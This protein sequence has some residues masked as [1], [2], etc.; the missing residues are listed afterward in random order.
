MTAEELFKK[1]ERIVGWCFKKYINDYKSIY[2]E[3][4]IQEGMLALWKCAKNF[5]ESRGNAFS[6]YAVPFVSGAMR[7]YYK[8]KCNVIR[9]PRIA[10]GDRPDIRAKLT[11]VLSLDMSIEQKDGSTTNIG[12]LIP[13]KPDTYEYLT[14]DVIDSFLETIPNTRDRGMMEEHYY[15]YVYGVKIT[16][17]E[18]ADK[19]NISQSYCAR[20]IVQYNKLFA[21]FLKDT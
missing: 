5:D 17:K 1:N 18:L 15:S 16:Q 19:Y 12:D 9:L 2:Y 11:N 6:T 20:L 13:G 3:D 7:Q 21:E 14:D 4:I 8:T 10:F